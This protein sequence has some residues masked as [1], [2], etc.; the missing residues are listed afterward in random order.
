MNS[1]IS[2]NHYR[3]FATE[4]RVHRYSL[5]KQ[6]LLNT[7]NSHLIDYPTPSNLNVS[8]NGGSLAGILLMAQIIT[9]VCLA[10]HY[11]AHVDLAFS[12]VQHINRRMCCLNSVKCLKVYI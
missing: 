7:L 4:T 5:L 9:G 6:P 2:K 10:M 11:T 1:N 3:F 8:W 12:S